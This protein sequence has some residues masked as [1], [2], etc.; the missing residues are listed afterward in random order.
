MKTFEVRVNMD[1][2]I[3]DEFPRFVS[4]KKFSFLKSFHLLETPR[5]ARCDDRDNWT[6][7]NNHD[8][9]IRRH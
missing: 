9:R 5:N 2:L 8:R 1:Y 6:G 7:V 3:D 4:R